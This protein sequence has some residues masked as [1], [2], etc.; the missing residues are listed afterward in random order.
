MNKDPLTIVDP[1]TVCPKCNGDKDLKK[2]CK[3][4]KSTGFKCV[5]HLNNI[6]FPSPGF[7]VCG[8]PSAYKVDYKRLGERGVVSVGVNNISAKI[9][10]TAWCFGDGT[11]RFHHGLFLDPKCLT[12]CP[13]PKLNERV[14]AKLP[15]GSFRYIDVLAKDC[16]NT[17]GFD[18]TM[19]FNK[20]EFLKSKKAQWSKNTTLY[21]IR[22]LHYLGCTKIYLLGVDHLVE[23]PYNPYA[24]EPSKKPR[25]TSFEEEIRLLTKIKEEFEKRNI[26]I[27]N[28][29]PDSKCDIFEFV[30]FN[31]AI[32]DCKN[33]VPNEPFGVAEYY[34]LKKFNDSE[35]SKI[36]IT[37][38]DLKKIQNGE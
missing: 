22:L 20:K 10:V 27:Y 17:Y 15:D 11:G 3:K 16:P 24:F 35:E 29:G 19:D 28:C 8:G 25:K 1:K 32:Q 31:D 21:G 23:D 37:R 7:L 30:D 14:R 12:F 18:K 26:K 5:D 38:E 33:F 6:W 9:P 13:I 34:D 2:E 36:I 4:C